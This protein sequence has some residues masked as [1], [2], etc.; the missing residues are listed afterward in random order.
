MEFKKDQIIV[1]ITGFEYKIKEI[2]EGFIFFYKNSTINTIHI[3][4]MK[5]YI[6]KS[7]YIIKK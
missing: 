2:K 5:R 7:F 6:K 1:S 4:T 3:N